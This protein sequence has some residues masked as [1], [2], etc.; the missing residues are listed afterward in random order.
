[1]AAAE[2]RGRATC[3]QS[4]AL[5]AE[6]RPKIPGKGPVPA[7]NRPQQAVLGGQDPVRLDR[8]LSGLDPEDAAWLRDRLDLPWRRRRRHRAARDAAVRDARIVFSNPQI[9]CAARSLAAALTAYV[10]SNFRIEKDVTTLSEG[11]SLRHVVLH[12]IARA[13]GG[14]PLGWRSIYGI[15]RLQ[16]SSPQIAIVPK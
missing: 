12:A 6:F 1:V 9:T 5:T 3:G 2:A 4:I 13:N 10:A 16:Q 14:R 11:A 15:W 8:I 7:E